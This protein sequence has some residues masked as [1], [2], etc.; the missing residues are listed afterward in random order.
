METVSSYSLLQSS[1]PV[2]RVVLFA[3]PQVKTEGLTTIEKMLTMHWT[4]TGSWSCCYVVAFADVEG[5]AGTVI[6]AVT[7]AAVAGVAAGASAH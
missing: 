7:L 3:A 5:L 6:A 2:R 4:L 1:V